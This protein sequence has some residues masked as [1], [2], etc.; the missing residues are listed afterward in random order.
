M[1]SATEPPAE[2][3]GKRKKIRTATEA[4]LWALS[5]GR[6]YA[7]ACR[8]PVVHEVRPGVYGKNAQ[9]AHIYGVRP[10]GPRYRPDIPAEIRDSFSNLL[11]LCYPH[12]TEIDG[13]EDRYPPDL[14]RAWKVGHEDAEVAPLNGL[15]LPDPDE[16]MEILTQV[17]SP[18]LDRLDAI[19]ERLER[20]GVANQETVDELKYVLRTLSTSEAG[21]DVRSAQ[22]LLAAS[23]ILSSMDINRSAMALLDAA[24]VL[25]AVLTR[26]EKAARRLGEFS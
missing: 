3:A 10:R 5:N 9:I 18:P 2:G 15:V 17:A 14:L 12:H 6:C 4:A 23:D 26:I 21:V 22:A 13:D 20:T 25:P 16:W 1:S 7:P 24:E 19:A 8:L 11:L